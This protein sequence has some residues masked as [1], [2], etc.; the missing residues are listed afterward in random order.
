MIPF[1]ELIIYIDGHKWKITP[2]CTLTATTGWKIQIQL[3]SHRGGDWVLVDEIRFMPG[4]G[5]AAL[6][7]WYKEMTEV[8]SAP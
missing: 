7:K 6:E 3:P 8:R 1:D 2:R 5:E 4:R